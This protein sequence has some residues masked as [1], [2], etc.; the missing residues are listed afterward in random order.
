M[1]ILVDWN[2]EKMTEIIEILS[3]T[4]NF[5]SLKLNNNQLNLNI[6]LNIYINLQAT[7]V[8]SRTIHI[9]QLWRIR[10][11]KWWKY[12]IIPRFFL[13]SKN[14]K[15]LFSCF[16]KI[17]LWLSVKE[18]LKQLSADVYFCFRLCQ[19]IVNLRNSISMDEWY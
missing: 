4:L 14:L 2:F 1:S 12:F 15:M 17:F 13:I 10:N 18:I 9:I 19:L 6:H 8:S 3:K 5:L 16:L 11:E 7:R